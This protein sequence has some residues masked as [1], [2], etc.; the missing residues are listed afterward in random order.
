MRTPFDCAAA[1][2]TEILQTKG[3]PLLRVTNRRPFSVGSFG[4]FSWSS[5]K[6]LREKA[7]EFGFDR[8]FYGTFW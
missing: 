8:A 2:R 6:I 4:I 5:R 1:M 7:W 3:A